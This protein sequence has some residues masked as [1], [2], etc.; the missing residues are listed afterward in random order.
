MFEA[1]TLHGH[2]AAGTL[3][4]NGEFIAHYTIGRNYRCCYLSFITVQSSLHYI[5]ERK[6]ANRI[7]KTV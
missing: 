5:N 2:S 7:H 3:K 1:N 4:T 6:H